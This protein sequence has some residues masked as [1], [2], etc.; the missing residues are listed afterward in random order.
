MARLRPNERALK[1]Y[2]DTTKSSQYICRACRAQQIRRL[3]ASTPAYVGDNRPWSQR[4]RDAV[5]GK[6]TDEAEQ[7]REEKAVARTKEMA[8]QYSREN[9][10]TQ[11]QAKDEGRVYNVA[12][13]VD[14]DVT[15]DYVAAETWENLPSV[16]SKQWAKQVKDGGEAYEG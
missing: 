3:H 11:R 4:I 10:Y 6:K 7:L 13:V 16:G 12:A 9:P 8:K 15:L 1:L 14:P 5:F 2:L